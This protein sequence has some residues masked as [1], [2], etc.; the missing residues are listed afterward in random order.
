M[1]LA[2][3]Q[4]RTTLAELPTNDHRP[5]SGLR[6]GGITHAEVNAAL[7]SYDK[8]VI[9]GQQNRL[10]NGLLMPD[11]KLKRFHAGHELVRFFYQGLNKLPEYLLDALLGYDM[12]VTLIAGKD[13][14]VFKDVRAHQAFHIGFTRKTIY[15][16][17]GI[18]R[19]AI[20]KGW[21]SWAISEGIIREAWPL[22]DY[23]LIL[24]F[25]RR[26]QQRLRTHV[27]LGTKT[28][29]KNA[30]RRLNKHLQEAENEMAE[31]DDFRAFFRH[32]C[33]AFYAMDRKILDRDPYEL[34]D[35]VYDEKQER[36]WAEVKVEG[37][38]SA[39]EFPTFF[40]LDRDIIHPAVFE[41]ADL[42]G[43]ATEPET[44]QDVLHDICDAARFKILR[45]T[46]TNRLLD[47]LVLFGRPG[48][49]GLVDIA[50]EESATGMR[51]LTENQGDGYDT[52][53]AF[54]A[55]LST[56]STSGPEGV[57]GSICH[58]FRDLLNY[59]IK[60][61]VLAL[62]H[63][64]QKLPAKEQKANKPYLQ[65]LLLKLIPLKDPKKQAEHLKDSVFVGGGNATSQREAELQ[66]MLT[67]T[68][69]QAKTIK[70]LLD[71]AQ[72]LVG[73][74]DPEKKSQLVRKILQKLDRH[75]D[76]HTRIRDQLSHFTGDRDLSLGESIVDQVEALYKSIPAHPYRLSSDPSYLRASL[77]DYE[78]LRRKNPNS[79]QMFTHL[80]G[81]LI[82]LD[83]TDN[84]GDFVQKVRMI[85]N[86]AEPELR[87]IIDHADTYDETR[88]TI[89]DTARDLYD[90]VSWG[91]V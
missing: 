75:P 10:R 89:L 38:T 21:D 68:V 41:S 56:Y 31:D 82:R 7:S 74:P 87:Y 44:T 46:K 16:P 42:R 18:I 80:A 1:A 34:A 83:K 36:R 52:M 14:L 57:V 8:T 51:Y 78:M 26:A 28:T 27:T 69:F 63:R 66:A 47:Q 40:D 30:L 53:T 2:Q 48:I 76:F 12:S 37:I 35:K 91:H 62:F 60:R 25:I 85:G 3:R 90:T 5:N 22:M 9:F 59:E 81:V 15:I 39:F 20:N 55:C 24:E 4:F 45:Q 6:E 86:D 73:P 23:L 43:Q 13:L 65:S 49:E 84:Y 54:K 11:E 29:I 64:F 17:E 77:R 61:Q 79:R 33:H 32:Y 58:D 67:A 88:Q 72:L 19:E 71:F 70:T 50:A